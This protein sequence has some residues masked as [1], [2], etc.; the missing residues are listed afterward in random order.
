MLSILRERGGTKIV[1]KGGK[2]E[3]AL[4]L[5]F[6]PPLLARQFKPNKSNQ[7]SQTSSAKES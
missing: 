2:L 5:F 6:A 4:H 1:K 7:F 3:L